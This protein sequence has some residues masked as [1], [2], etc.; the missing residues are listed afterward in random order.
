M[1]KKFYIVLLFI[2]IILSGCASVEFK[3]EKPDDAI[4]MAT[5]EAIGEEFY[6]LGKEQ[7]TGAY[8]YLIRHFDNKQQDV[9]CDAIAAINEII[10][11]EDVE[12]KVCIIFCRELSG[13]ATS[14][15]LIMTNYSDDELEKPDCEGL[16]HLI[17]TG[18]H[19]DD[20]MCKKLNTYTS[21]SD[22]KY[23]EI[24]V[25]IQKKFKDEGMEWFD[26]YSNLENIELL[27][28]NSE[29]KGK[30]PDDVISNVIFD[31]V[32]YEIFY[33]G[34]NEN[35][36]ESYYKYYIRDKW[37]DNLELAE[38]IS[39]VTYAVNEIIKEEMLT[40]KVGIK[41]Y[42]E[43]EMEVFS[44]YNYYD[45]KLERP[46]LEGLQ[47]LVVTGNTYSSSKYND[48]L[49][50]SLIPDIKYLE[51]KEYINDIAYNS[52]NNWYEYWDDLES[53]KVF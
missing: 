44:L 3:N 29:F 10:R 4:T 19:Y 8:R 23:M 27:D 41:F 32:G 25:N 49:T 1:N 47:R 52:G 35:E 33:L 6:Y 7:Y 31:A 36:E 39:D 46:D 18:C 22:I 53:I 9:L 38:T 50:Y 26:I 43:P 42:Y 15:C 28:S 40:Q 37:K 14:N 20:C 16:Q 51:V 30:M 12:E 2:V 13:G 21:L 17:I 5:Y 34:K 48:S 24:D 11:K 45:S